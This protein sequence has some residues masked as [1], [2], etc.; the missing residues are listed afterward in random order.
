MR[1][2]RSGQFWQHLI[3]HLQRVFRFEDGGDIV[4]A[5][6]VEVDKKVTESEL[7]P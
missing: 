1:V 6:G 5:V 3:Q 2:V 4:G 7:S